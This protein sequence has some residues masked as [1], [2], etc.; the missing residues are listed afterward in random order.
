MP[1]V[2]R[3]FAFDPGDVSD[4]RHYTRLQSDG[5]TITLP[6]NQNTRFC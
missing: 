4:V 3:L 1:A 5:Q 6:Q 2:G